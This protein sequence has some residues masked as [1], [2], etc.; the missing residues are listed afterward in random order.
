MS[1]RRDKNGRLINSGDAYQEFILGL[2]DIVAE[3]QEADYSK[4]AC[5]L[6]QEARRMFMVE[7]S[8]KFPDRMSGRA[9]FE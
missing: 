1:R 4:E 6:L 8:K 9:V 2:N 7:F 5:A 3:A